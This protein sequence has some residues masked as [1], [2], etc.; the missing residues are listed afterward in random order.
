VQCGRTRQQQC[1]S[2][3]PAGTCKSSWAAPV[4][5]DACVHGY[6][7]VEDSYPEQALLHES[8]ALLIST[9]VLL[10]ATCLLPCEQQLS[11]GV[12]Q[13]RLGNEGM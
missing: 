4:V 9:H 6:S 7:P 13:R 8:I 10:E 2:H 5:Q 3:A 11:D 12:D 1:P